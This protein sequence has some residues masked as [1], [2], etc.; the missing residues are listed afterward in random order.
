MLRPDRAFGTAGAAGAGSPY[1]G[2]KLLIADRGNNR[3]LLMDAA[4]HVVRKYPS[5]GLPLLPDGS[6]PTHTATG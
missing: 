1:S 3:L 5:P 2:A 4:M 6:T